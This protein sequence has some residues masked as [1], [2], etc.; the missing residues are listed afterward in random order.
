MMRNL[1][2]D[3]T[4]D[5][6]FWE[7]YALLWNNSKGK[8]PFQ[9]PQILQFFS[10]K[11]AGRAIAIRLLD[12]QK[13]IGAVILKNDNGT[14]SF[15]SDLK[16]DANFFV[17]H[18]ECSDGDIGFFFTGILEIIKK[19]NWAVMFNYVPSWADYMPMFEQCSTKSNLFFQAI[20]YS[21]CPVVKC[22]TPE[23]VL[24]IM[25]SSYSIRNVT[26]KL[27]TK[28]NAGIE[29][30]TGD[31]D[32][33][34]WVREFCISHILR[35]ENTSTP[36]AF[37]NTDRQF[38]LLKCLRAWSADKIL[39]RFAIKVNQQRVGFIVGLVENKSLVHHSTTF[40]PDYYKFSPAKG[41][42]LTMAEWM[43][44]KKLSILNFGDG[45]EKYKY[46]FANKEW[47]LKK[48][49]ISR[50]TNYSF[51]T[52]AKLIN[53][54]KRYPGVYSFYQMKIKKYLNRRRDAKIKTGNT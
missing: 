24:D 13:L 12:D 36:S 29:V 33:E 47:V 41:L 17:F 7:E 40:H 54:I 26:N 23:E 50:K 14:Y 39:I 11:F 45:N 19:R 22:N 15:L 31:E 42:L 38:F 52:K 4:L 20:D 25:K 34:N 53:L 1:I 44:E 18:K 21:V 49:M 46:S 43:V 16:T 51:V 6:L 8:S 3:S 5:R 37:R 35:W 30:L 9:A 28:L 48:V 27:R 2:I 32:L 10:G